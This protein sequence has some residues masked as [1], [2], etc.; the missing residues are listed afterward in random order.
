MA[1]GTVLLTASLFMR[2]ALPPPGELRHELRNE[3]LQRA[4]T[5]WRLATVLA[6]D[7]VRA[8]KL[9]LMAR[10]LFARLQQVEEVKAVDAWLARPQ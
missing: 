10:E 8:R 1:A 4:E 9:A 6:D 5:A 2:H 3:P 7:P